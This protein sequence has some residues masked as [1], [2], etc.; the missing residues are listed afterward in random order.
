MGGLGRAVGVTQAHMLSVTQCER[1][2]NRN[3]CIMCVCVH[4]CSSFVFVCAF[5]N[6]V[7]K[8]QDEIDAT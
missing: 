2:T 4:A 7:L 1:E 6:L 3:I 5:V 8:L